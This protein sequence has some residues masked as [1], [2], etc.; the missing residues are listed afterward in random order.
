MA[1]SPQ[2]PR[3]R[4]PDDFIYSSRRADVLMRCLQ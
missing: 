4:L 1:I 3:Q 2:L